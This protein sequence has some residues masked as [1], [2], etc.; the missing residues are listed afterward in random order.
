MEP[1]RLVA[2][3]YDRI[4]LAYEEWGGGHAGLR[5]RF[6]DRAIELGVTPP[7]T[8]LDLG[9]GTGR[10]GTAYLVEQGFD[11]IGVDSSTKSIEAARVALPGARFLV[12]DMTAI[13]I[14]ESSLDLVTAFY[15]IIHVPRSEHAQLLTRIVGWLRPG[16]LFVAAMGGDEGEPA[17]HDKSWLGLAPMYWSFWDPATSRRLMSDAGLDHVEDEEELLIEDSQEVSFWWV[18]ARKTSPP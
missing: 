7:A 2:D 18:I 15:S 12:G 3:S 13:A 4:H 9:C 17:G 16:G 10:H 14:P 6:I 11:V 5:H 1:K 8:V